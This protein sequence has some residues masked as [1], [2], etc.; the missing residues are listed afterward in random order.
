MSII[1]KLPI[2]IWNIILI[3]SDKK[4]SKSF[5]Y[6]SSLHALFSNDELKDLKYKYIYDYIIAKSPIN[7]HIYDIYNNLDNIDNHSKYISN[8]LKIYHDI[9]LLDRTIININES[10]ILRNHLVT[11][12]KNDL[13]KQKFYNLTNKIID[14]GSKCKKDIKKMI[15]YL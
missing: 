10:I 12:I 5:I 9:C 14:D 3:F 4:G 11:K 13:N 7:I 6:M 8:Y 1:D 2:E 15:D